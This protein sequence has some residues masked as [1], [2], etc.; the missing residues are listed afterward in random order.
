MSNYLVIAGTGSIGKCVAKKLLQLGHHVYITGREE[1]KTQ[2]IAQELDVPFSILEASDFNAVDACFESAIEKMGSLNGVV[3]CAGSLLL[4]PAHLINQKEYDHVILS[5]LTTAFA[6]VRSAGK[7]M[8]QEGGSIVLV[9]SAAALTGIANHESIASAKAGMIGLTLSAAASYSSYN[10]RFNA[11]A[12]GLVES[13]LTASIINN[14]QSRKASQAM[15]ALGRLG[16]PEDIASAIIFL[17]LEENN[18]ITGQVLGVDGGL[19]R[20]RPKIKI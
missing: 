5:N 9:S 17:L 2:P 18:W 13:H 15:H 1:T 3:N 20:I 12:P 14:E 11:V 10:L 16:K 6:T 19:S 4:K 7:Y 8:I